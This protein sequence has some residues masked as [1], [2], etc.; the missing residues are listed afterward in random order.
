MIIRY[1]SAV[2]AGTLTTLTILYAMQGLIQLQPGAEV[3]VRDHDILYWLP[4]PRHDDPPQR[5]EPVVDRDL[6][7]KSP[8][9]PQGPANTG[10]GTG[11]R[12]TGPAPDPR[13][14]DM[15]MEKLGQP[16]GPLISIVRVQPTYPAA[17]E[18]RGIEGWVDVRFDVMTDGQVVNIDVLS[19]SHRIFE[20]SAIRAAQ[21]FRFRAPVVNGVPQIATGIEYRFRFTMN[22]G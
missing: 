16:D 6:I 3:P 17:A 5:E 14:V 22:S 8:V 13:S 19:S 4:A 9:P 2:T 15:T 1:A 7:S 18:A 11:L 12:I 20:N 21:R 10:G